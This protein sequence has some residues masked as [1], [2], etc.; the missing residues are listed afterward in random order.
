M[1]SLI[2]YK[3]FNLIPYI[4]WFL[5]LSIPLVFTKFNF[6]IKVFFLIF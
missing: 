2:L 5:V 4:F 6:D 1:A 3:K